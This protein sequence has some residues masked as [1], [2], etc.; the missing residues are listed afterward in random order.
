[1]GGPLRVTGIT[2]RPPTRKGGLLQIPGGLH[3]AAGGPG[4]NPGWV[5]PRRSVPRQLLRTTAYRF[6]A[7][8]WLGFTSN[9]LKVNTRPRPRLRLMP[10]PL[11]A[12]WVEPRGCR[13]DLQCLSSRLSAS[14]AMATPQQLYRPKPPDCSVRS[15]PEPPLRVKVVGLFKSS[16]FQMSKTIAEV[17]SPQRDYEHHSLLAEYLQ[18]WLGSSS[19]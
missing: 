10:R 3:E 11:R 2:G 9:R 4:R 7:W 13:G 18:R 6:L 17:T 15:P 14:A 8:H 12:L 19:T 5:T 1:M 16:S